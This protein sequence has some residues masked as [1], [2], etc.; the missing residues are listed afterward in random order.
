MK[1]LLFI[2][3]LTLYINSNAQKN[4]QQIWI[5]NSTTT[6]IE[7]N[8]VKVLREGI[9]VCGYFDSYTST[10]LPTSGLLFNN[11][12]QFVNCDF[13]SID[14]VSGGIPGFNIFDITETK[15]NLWA[16][17]T[18]D[19]GLQQQVLFKLDST[20][21]SWNAEVILLD[22]T[23]YRFVE[24]VDDSTLILFGRKPQPGG[25]TYSKV[26]YYNI[27]SGT[28]SSLVSG[29]NIYDYTVHITRSNSDNKLY[30]SGRGG[31]SIY[32]ISTKTLSTGI[33]G[34]QFAS[35]TGHGDTLY[36][37]TGP[38]GDFFQKI[39]GG[40]WNFLGKTNTGT[41][42]V[43]L[44]E[45]NR[46]GLLQ[47]CNQVT[48]PNNAIITGNDL[49]YNETTGAIETSPVT[50]TNGVNWL[51]KLPNGEYIGWNA[52]AAIWTT[53]VIS[54]LNNLLEESLC[55]YP[56][57]ATN[58]LFIQTNGTAVSEVNI[59]NTTGSLVNQTNQPQT[60]S[61]D[62]S[63]L[64]NGVYIAEIKT[65]EASVMRRWVKM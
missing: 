39:G 38:T 15:A 51:S 55:V 40:S 20:N 54:G 34:A 16:I 46:I 62:I 6:Q 48:L 65:K 24:A 5:P 57:P 2:L 21:N 28:T 63:Q 9:F 52:S 58:Q 18:S 36:C 4:L 1:N 31:C 17:G 44:T 7:G 56:N 59:Y 23:L 64:A 61:I 27:N 60:K 25:V 43:A 29:L 49:S 42:A 22:T 13:T 8:N 53:Q 3:T 35:F 41:A 37:G 47:G 32:D 33:N 45:N 30:I 10:Q 26:C 11:L 19:N 50:N 14:N 12:I